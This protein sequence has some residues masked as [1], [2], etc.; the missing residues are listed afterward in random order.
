MKNA[1][2]ANNIITPNY[3]DCLDFPQSKLTNIRKQKVNK[4]KTNFEWSSPITVWSRLF[5]MVC[6]LVFRFLFQRKNS[7]EPDCTKWLNLHALK[8]VFQLM[9]LKTEI[10]N[11]KSSEKTK[12]SSVTVS[13][14]FNWFRSNKHSDHCW[15]TLNLF[16]SHFDFTIIA[17]VSHAM[18]RMKGRDK[19]KL[20][21]PIKAQSFENYIG[22]DFNGIRFGYLVWVVLIQ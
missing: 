12:I 7:R 20:K 1:S 17:I 2:D 8:S 10:T 4:N 22:A 21:C 14:D 9:E 16:I 5:L 15:W 11:E 6:L 3:V 13:H 18:K 19:Q